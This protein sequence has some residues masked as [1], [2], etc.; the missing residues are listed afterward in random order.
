[1]SKAENVPYIGINIQNLEKRSI[2]LKIAS[3]PELVMGR[4]V[5]KSIVTCSN[6]LHGFSTG[7]NK[8]TGNWVETRLD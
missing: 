5:I 8:P 6:G 3:K 1:M 4:W 7:C 2:M